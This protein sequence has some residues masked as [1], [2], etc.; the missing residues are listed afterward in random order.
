M[1][2]RLVRR[3]EHYWRCLAALLLCPVEAAML[4]WC[5]HNAAGARVWRTLALR[6]CLRRGVRRCL[7]LRLQVLKWRAWW[8]PA[9]AAVAVLRV[10]LLALVLVF[11]LF[12]P[13]RRHLVPETDR[14]AHV[15]EEPTLAR[16]LER[17]AP[18]P[19]DAAT[20]HNCVFP[21]RK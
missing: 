13:F 9:V 19:V 16:M 2:L 11:P 5:D 3:L 10:R 4:L 6:L 18:Q 21:C 7:S 17:N 1:R 14:I 15:D 20:Y 12:F 8:Q